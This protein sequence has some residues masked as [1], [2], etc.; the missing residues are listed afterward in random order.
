MNIFKLVF[1]E[2]LHRKSQL[3][4]GLLAITLGIAIIVGI[5][6]VSEFS[7][8]A[9]AVQL[10]N[11]GANILILPQASSID[12]YY[13]ADIDAPTFP[14]E[15]VDRIVNSTIQ[16]V[17]NLS[18]KLTRRIDIGPNKVV[19]TGI[20]PKSEIA[21]KPI[22]QQSGLLGGEIAAS[23][24]PSSAENKSTGLE[25]EK[26]QRKVIDTLAGFDCLVGSLAA[27]KLKVKE[28]D[29]I[30]IQGTSFN[31]VRILQETGTV[32]DDR[33]FANIASVQQV[34]GI[35]NQ[36]SAI[37]VMGC[38]NAISDGLLGKLRNILPDTRITTISQIVSTQIGT[39]QM[40]K[41]VSLV[42]LIII[43]FVGGISIGNYIWANVNERRKEIGILRMMG[44]SRHKIHLLLIS[45]AVFL[46]VAGGILGYIIGTLAGV[47]LGPY[48]ANIDV[49]PVPIL[50][51][52]SILIAVVISVIG[53]IIPAW[54]AGKIEPFSTMQEV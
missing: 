31:V 53:S 5:R 13:S 33:I 54:L 9:V 38:C 16:G 49:H 18:P 39:N 3:I 22:W 6:S 40:M 32:D 42:F 11:L 48:L 51:L 30:P 27:Q 10:D 44:Y 35:P 8:K 17:D 26:L 7:E 21:S 50:F 41:K 15:Y 29:S 43:L 14:Q 2:L 12:N 36:V 28:G 34:L 23:C 20:L 4:S 1:L 52:W 46:G 37:E 19:L 25:D 47:F 45:K 24:D